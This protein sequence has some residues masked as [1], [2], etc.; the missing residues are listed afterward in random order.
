[1]ILEKEVTDLNGQLELLDGKRCWGYGVMRVGIVCLA[2]FV[3]MCVFDALTGCGAAW[4][5]T[6]PLAQFD[7]DVNPLFD[8]FRGMIRLARITMMFVAA[9]LGIICGV[10]WY[11]GQQQAQGMLQKFFVAV[12]FIFGATA[13]LDA[14]LGVTMGTVKIDAVEHPADV[15]DN[16]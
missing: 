9:L 1:M 3:L 4:A 15:P 16:W 14:V 6:G 11:T 2:V 8:M 13:I 7:G 12:F 5:A 10:M